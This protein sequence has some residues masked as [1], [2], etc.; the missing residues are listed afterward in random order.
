[1]APSTCTRPFESYTHFAG[2]LLGFFGAQDHVEP[3]A[4]EP[5]RFASSLHG[6]FS[7]FAMLSI[8]VVG[9][10]RITL[11]LTRRC[12]GTRAYFIVSGSCDMV[13]A[14]CAAETEEAGF[15]KMMVIVVTWE[16]AVLDGVLLKGS[17]AFCSGRDLS[18]LQMPDLSIF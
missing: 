1:M 3:F 5:F 10:E 12:E 2:D 9:D 7:F 13:C 16:M 18:A 14:L 15:A 11:P 6:V 17:T 4:R 8:G